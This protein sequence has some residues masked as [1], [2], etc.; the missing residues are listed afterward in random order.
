MADGALF[1]ISMALCAP[2]ATGSGGS[3]CKYEQGCSDD[4]RGEAGK[5]DITAR[6][7]GD[8]RGHAAHEIGGDRVDRPLQKEPDSGRSQYQIKI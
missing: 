7:L 5:G 4:S 3:D 6:H 8:A 2:V 1:Q